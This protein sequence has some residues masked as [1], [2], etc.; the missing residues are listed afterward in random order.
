M[1]SASVRTDFYQT[2]NVEGFFS[3][4]VTFDFIIS[5]YAADL[6]YIIFRKISDADVSINSCFA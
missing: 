6:C 5:E 2:F 3:T 4:K 1:T